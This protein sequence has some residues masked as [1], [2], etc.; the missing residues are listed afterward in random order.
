MSYLV[1]ES[2]SKRFG[3]ETVLDDVSLTVEQGETVVVFGPSGC[4]K[5]V[6]LRLIAGIH[7]PDGGTIRIGDQTVTMLAPEDRDVGMAFQNFALYPH[8]SAFENIASPLR[9]RGLPAAEVTRRV[10]ELAALLK[11][12]HVLGHLPRALSNGQKQR[13]SLARSLAPGPSV[14]LLD[15]PLRNVDA[16]LR[17]EMRLELPRVLKAFNAT[18][19]YVTQDYKEAMALGHRVA[20]LMDGGFVQIDQP[21]RLYTQPASRDVA[22]MFGDPAINLYQAHAR[23]GAI[24]LFGAHFPVPATGPCLVGIR[25]EH[26]EVAMEERPGAIPVELDAVTPL[27]VR[28]VLLLKTKGGQEILATCWEDEAARFPRGHRAV[29][30]SLRPDDLM[31]FDAASGAR[32]APVAA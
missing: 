7:E 1:L 31:L 21:S 15:D 17:Y 20:V 29:W 9:A 30:A 25:P 4:G 5:T 23:D 24:E 32:L 11:I 12:E 10:E 13:T 3:R 26:V 19:L 28:A 22:R 16:K 18:V 27:N 6:L 2:L 8:M 14:L